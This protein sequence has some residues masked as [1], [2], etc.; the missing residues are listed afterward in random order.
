MTADPG[1]G[2]TDV[3][4]GAYLGRIEAVGLPDVDVGY[5]LL[6][7]LQRRHLLTVPFENLD[8]VAG[9]PITLDRAAF[10]E[11]IVERE[12]GGFCYELNGLFA[13]LLSA[14]GFETRMVGGRVTRSDGSLGPPGD[15]LAIVVDLDDPY[16]VDVGFGDFARVPLPMTG[17]PISD[18]GGTWRVRVDPDDPD[19][20]LAQ[21]WS[22]DGWRTE[23]AF[24]TETRQLEFFAE[25]CQHHQTAPESPFVGE[26]VVTIATETGRVTLR[27]GTLTVTDHGLKR[28][29]T[30]PTAEE[31]EQILRERF[32]I[33]PP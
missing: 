9:E 16:L 20:F 8:V 1:S 18:V 33:D 15:H 21:S 10:A 30:V 24:T 12:R 19:A 17:E 13:G 11:K 2:A 7:A 5:D 31:R 26:P 3:D 14:L 23:Y 6:A 32:G 29:Q 4:V 28:T 22:E 27:P 25:A